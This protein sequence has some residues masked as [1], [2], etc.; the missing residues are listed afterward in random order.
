MVSLCCPPDQWSV[1]R[2][3][4]LRDMVFGLDSSFSEKAFV[5][6]INSDL[7][8]DLGNL[9]SRTM[10]M[11]VKYADGRVPNPGLPD[12]EDRILGET[13]AR[14]V[15]EEESGFAEFGF[16]KALIAIWGGLEEFEKVDL[17]A[18]KVIA[19]ERVPKS[20]KLLKLT[21]EIDGE[22]QILAGN[23]EGLRSSPRP[24]SAQY[25]GTKS[26]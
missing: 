19:A 12:D 6:R 17:R 21:V 13:A 1:I 5:Q 8:N 9:V 2:Y 23:G 22:R 11:A 3:F 25:A 4:L 20:N 10:T 24:A 26:P 16:H 18:A 14:A 7:A 15:A